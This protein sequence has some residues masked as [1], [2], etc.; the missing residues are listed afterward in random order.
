MQVRP[1]HPDIHVLLV[2]VLYKHTL[3]ANT[4][5]VYGDLV[6]DLTAICLLYERNYTARYSNSTNR[7]IATAYHRL[8]AVIAEQVSCVQELYVIL[9]LD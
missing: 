2:T 5:E 4:S 6:S 7:G 1:L 8:A 3:L 9:V